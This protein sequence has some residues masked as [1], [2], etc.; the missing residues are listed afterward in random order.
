LAR[1]RADNSEALADIRFGAHSGLKSGIAPCPKSANIGSAS[2]QFIV[3][4]T[5]FINPGP[6]M[7]LVVI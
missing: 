4:A 1:A 3:V 7:V 2:H 5:S 6:T